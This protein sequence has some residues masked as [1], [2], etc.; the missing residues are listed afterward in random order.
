[1]LLVGIQFIANAVMLKLGIT[2][3]LMRP[4]IGDAFLPIAGAIELKAI[5]SLGLWDQNHPAAAVM[6]TVVIL[7]GVLCKRAFCGWA[8]RQLPFLTTWRGIIIRLPSLRWH[9]SLSL[10]ALS[11]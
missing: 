4:D 3:Y 5:I 1:M 9:S 11:L 7:T 10:L 2:P 6:L 8:C